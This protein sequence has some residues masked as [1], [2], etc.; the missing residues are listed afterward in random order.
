[1]KIKIVAALVVLTMTGLGIAWATGQFSPD[2]DLAEIEEI[3]TKIQE[4]FEQETSEDEKAVHE[5]RRE[6]FE[7]VRDKMESMP[8][9][10]QDAA[11]RQIQQFFMAQMQRR[12]DEFFELPPEERMA[13]LDEHIDRMERMYSEREKRRAEREAAEGADAAS[14]VD[15]AASDGSNAAE[16][17]RRGPGP[18]G[19]GRGGPGRFR[20]A[21]P[22]QRDAW[23]REMLDNTS[24]EQRAKF[25]EFRKLVDE[26]RKER[27]LPD[28]RF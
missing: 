1:M 16:G 17:Q 23:R 2:K 14:G 13:K 5:E 12:M 27:G 26:R 21:T 18:G 22:E 3:Q 28:R 10:K 24:P 9:E 6:L 20:D 4:S 11:R 15:N 7:Q 19:R 25:M 8:E